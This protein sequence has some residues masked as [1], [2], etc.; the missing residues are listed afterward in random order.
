LNAVNIFIV[1]EKPQVVYAFTGKLA[2][3]IEK[4]I[5]LGV[6]L[7][8]ASLQCVR[9]L[10]QNLD[11]GCKQLGIPV[12]HSFAKLVETQLPTNSFTGAQL[13]MIKLKQRCLM[14][15]EPKKKGGYFSSS[16]LVKKQL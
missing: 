16:Q 1:V 13:P 7:G 6:K 3:W 11:S 15:F 4:C 12:H 9:S 14:Q 2:C 10:F 5:N 8:V